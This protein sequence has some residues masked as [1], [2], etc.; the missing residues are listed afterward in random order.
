MGIVVIP[1]L[2]PHHLLDLASPNSP[3]TPPP[4]S[5]H[6]D[7]VSQVAPPSPAASRL[8]TVNLSLSA[9]YSH[10]YSGLGCEEDALAVQLLE[11]APRT[12]NQYSAV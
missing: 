6:Q 11:H 2:S 1:L 5:S 9:I 3:S 8:D 10:F 7:P 4:G 12:F